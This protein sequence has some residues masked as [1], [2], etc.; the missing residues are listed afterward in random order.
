M[1]Y[2]THARIHLQN[3]RANLEGIRQTVGP[4]RKILIAV[5]A[6]AYGHG[7]VEVARLAEA[8][9]ID[10][11]GV[12]TVPS[13]LRLRDAGITLPILKFNVTFPE[14]MQAALQAG[15][16]LAVCSQDNLEA[17]ETVAE[18]LGLQ[19]TV[20]LKVDTGMGRVGVEPDQAPALAAFLETQCPHLRLQGVFTHLPSS[21]EADPT[22]TRD[23][24]ARFKM[25]VAE[26]EKAIGRKLELVHC[27]N[28]GGVLGHE[29][30]WLNLVRPGI[31]VYGFY[32]S[33]DTPR[34]IPLKPGLSFLTRVSFLKRVPGGT[35]IGYGRTWTAPSDTWIATLPVGYADGFNRLFS[36]F[37]RV[38]INGQSY[39]VAG[40]AC[41]DQTMVDLGPDTTVQVGD[42]VVLIGRSGAEEIT[43]YEWAQK[44]GTITYEITCQINHRVE[45]IYDAP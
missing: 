15:L 13:G 26:I 36:N 6:N 18:G 2:Q 44:L 20:H 22:F 27:A 9:G 5:K 38:L 32:P 39:P 8:T 35:T 7:S 33:Q 42:E 41:M 24:V 19:A 23:Q 34:S 21:D 1:L 30:A 4:Q 12:A 37:G 11:L 3:I 43:A 25:I 14:E 16:T 28:S 40:R 17:M 29:D 10:W 31:M 45:R